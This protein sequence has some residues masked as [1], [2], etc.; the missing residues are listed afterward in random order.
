MYSILQLGSL[1]DRA[2]VRAIDL[3]CYCMPAIESIDVCCV[4]DLALSSLRQCGVIL[5]LAARKKAV[6][7]KH[8]HTQPS[9]GQTILPASMIS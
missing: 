3:I 8:T 4:N 7:S 6:C 5:Q 2:L 1:V 9:G